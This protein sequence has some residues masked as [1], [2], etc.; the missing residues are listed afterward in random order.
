MEDHKLKIF[1]KTF[2]VSPETF[3]DPGFLLRNCGL[4]N[5]LEYAALR[6]GNLKRGKYEAFVE[7]FGFA[8]DA[9]REE[10]EAAACV[11]EKSDF[12]KKVLKALKRPITEVAKW[13]VS[14][15]C[16]GS[17][18]SDDPDG[19][20]MNAAMLLQEAAI[21][22]LGGESEKSVYGSVIAKGSIPVEILWSA[23]VQS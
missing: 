5:V 3:G 12:Y 22:L 10:V 7:T 19:L 9:G 15:D 6:T 4:N 8:F 18:I 23:Y 11:L 14:A 13:R 17:S 2:A 20:R 21:S 16:L 1:V